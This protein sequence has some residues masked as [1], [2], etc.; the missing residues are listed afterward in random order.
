[1]CLEAEGGCSCRSQ[2][3]YA[4]QPVQSDH[5]TSACAVA[6]HYIYILELNIYKSL[7][8]GLFSLW[9][10]HN[11]YSELVIVGKLFCR[12]SEAPSR[13]KPN[14]RFKGCV[15]CSLKYTVGK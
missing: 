13:V 3:Q 9:F 5:E 14:A 4:L 11:D 7:C 15:N 10:L 1:M 2:G 6:Q 12:L 8:S